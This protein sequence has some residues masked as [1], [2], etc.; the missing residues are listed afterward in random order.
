[1]DQLQSI[2]S[3]LVSI[4]I[5][6]ETL[7]RADTLEG[8]VERLRT[9]EENREKLG[10]WSVP[11]AAVVIATL[12][13]LISQTNRLIGHA[14]TCWQMLGAGLVMAGMLWTVYQFQLTCIA[15]RADDYYQPS[16]VFLRAVRQK[17]RQRKRL[18]VYGTGLYLVLLIPGTHL[19]LS[20][21]LKA[22]PGYGGFVGLL[23]GGMLGVGGWII[24]AEQRRFSRQYG[25]ILT[26]IDQF[27]EQ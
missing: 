3:K 8:A 21:Y 20:D 15:F 18:T 13:G 22:L 24:N 6:L 7:L 10:K 5:E 19:I 9:Q 16:S 14:A 25:D 17:L 27:L 26:R 1:M 11:A 4:Q 12:L 2:W 23:Y